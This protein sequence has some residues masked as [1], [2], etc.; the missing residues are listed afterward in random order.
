MAGCYTY[1]PVLTP[2]PA[3]GMRV[4]L[5]LSEEGRFEAARQV[6]P[7]AVRVEGAVVQTTDADYVVSVTDVVD[8]RGERS[9]WAGELLPLRRSYVATTYERRFSRGR[10]LFLIGGLASAF[11]AAVLGFD[12]I[13]FGTGGDPGVPPPPD[14]NGQ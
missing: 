11:V 8:I 2:Q 14:P 5:V 1:V 12:F 9:K 10:T 4:S 3:A 13:V 7:Y 6:G